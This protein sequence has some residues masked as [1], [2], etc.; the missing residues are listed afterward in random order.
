[1]KEQF[2]LVSY[3]ISNDKRRAKAA[4]ILEGCGRRV[5][6]S[7]FEC[8]ITSERFEILY[9]ELLELMQEEE[10]GSIRI[11]SLCENCRKKITEIGVPRASFSPEEEALFIV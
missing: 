1:M 8:S 7:V 9:G 2:Y 5:Q 3:D 4:K 11:Y 10:Q 6:Y